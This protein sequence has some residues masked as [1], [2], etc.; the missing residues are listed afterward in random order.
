MP[1]LMRC[2][3]ALAQAQRKRSAMQ[4]VV[5]DQERQVLADPLNM[6]R[7]ADSWRTAS[8][9]PT[10]W[11]LSLPAIVQVNCTALAMPSRTAQQMPDNDELPLPTTLHGPQSH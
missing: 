7:H 9:R 1:C 6:S 3:A 10:C 5:F 4:P 8:G 11:R 2:A